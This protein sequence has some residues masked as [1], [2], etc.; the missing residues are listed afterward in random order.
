MNK[1]NAVVLGTGVWGRNH[2]RIYSSLKNVH[3]FGVVDRDKARAKEIGDYYQTEYY[4]DGED[5]IKNPEVDLV[6][7]CTP[8]VTHAILTSSALNLGKNVL[9][10]KPMTN[11]ICEA[12]NL[13]QLAKENNV[14]F[15]VGFVERF[16]PAVQ[17]ALKHIKQG[18]IG[19]VILANT[20]R[21]S[22]R[23]HRIGDVGVVKDLAIHDIDIIAKMFPNSPETIY[24]TCGSI[25]HKFEDYANI[26]VR[27][28]DNRNAFIETNWLTPS[29]KRDLTI[30]GTEGVITVQYRTQQITI[31]N[32]EQSIRP[33]LPTQEPL[34]NELNAFVNC[35]IN[36]TEPVVTGADGLKALTIAEAALESNRTGKTVNYSDFLN[37][38]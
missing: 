34:R 24:A 38:Y 3:L 31:E 29:V 4:T 32:N 1:L 11:T 19:D 12:K 8:T 21:V 30:T 17:E 20:R 16:N 25:A 26:N 7:I 35:I 6:S 22:R 15:T 37:R 23:P 36:D 14:K 27:Y 9:V 33:Y 10:E 5:V 13:I 2:A 18:T 28:K